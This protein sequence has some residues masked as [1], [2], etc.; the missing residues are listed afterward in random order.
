MDARGV[1]EV[2]KSI[3]SGGLLPFVALFELA[4]H[5]SVTLAREPSLQPGADLLDGP[6]FM[7]RDSAI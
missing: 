6:L 4:L 5:H 2:P 1:A 3:E 7:R